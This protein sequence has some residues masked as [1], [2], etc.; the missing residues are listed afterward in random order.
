MKVDCSF[1]FIFL[2]I[3]MYAYLV[4]VCSLCVV[5][6]EARRGHLTLWS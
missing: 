1:L 2:F 3:L 4:Y 5:P 6:A